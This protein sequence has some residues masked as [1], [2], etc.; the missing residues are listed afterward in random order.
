MDCEMQSR[1][2]MARDT[3]LSEEWPLHLAPRS[4]EAHKLDVGLTLVSMRTAVVWPVPLSVASAGY[5]ESPF[6]SLNRSLVRNAFEELYGTEVAELHFGDPDP[7]DLAISVEA[8][9]ENPQF[10]IRNA[11][12]GSGLS[13][14]IEPAIEM[15]N[16]SFNFDEFHQLSMDER[17][18]LA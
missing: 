1:E 13:I 7:D 4:I 5:I 12:S 18:L 2:Q 15:I 17:G 9:V 3:L 16:S 6:S 10:H 11:S 14:A 8:I